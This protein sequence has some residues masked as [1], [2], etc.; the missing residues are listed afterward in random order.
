MATATH[1]ATRL[2]YDDEGA[3]TAVVFLHGLTFDRRTWRPIID[4]L[5]GSVRSIAIDLPA[6]GDSGGRPGP[7]D[8]VAG[9]V[10]ELLGSLAVDEPVMVGHSMSG[11][12]VCSYAASYPSRGLVMVDS[13]PD[14]RPFARVVQRMET[15]LRGPGFGELWRTFEESLGLELIPEPSRSL[16]LNSHEVRQ[17]VVLGYWEAVLRADPDEFQAFIDESIRQ[18]DVPCLGVFGRP[19]TDSERER[20]GWLRDVQLEAWVGDGHFVHLVEPDRFVTRLRQ[21][22]EHC[23]VA[24]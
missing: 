11:G 20:F 1:S 5:D 9:Y 18:L 10:H 7:L 15:A 13:G 2:A 3:G 22:V 12:L 14:V 21:F 8:E 23:T 17:D 24:S 16:V 6:H 4:R 19:I